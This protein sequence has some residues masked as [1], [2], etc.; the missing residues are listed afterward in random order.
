MLRPAES[1]AAG[2]LSNA[3]FMPPHEVQRHM[4]LLWA[5]ERAI[6]ERIWGATVPTAADTSAARGTRPF[7]PSSPPASSSSSSPLPSSPTH[8]CLAVP[9]PLGVACPHKLLPQAHTRSRFGLPQGAPT[10]LVLRLPSDVQR[11]HRLALLHRTVNRHGF[12]LRLTQSPILMVVLLQR[13]L[14]RRATSSSRWSPCRPT[15]SARPPCSTTS[16]SR[17]LRTS[18]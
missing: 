10:Y 5:R 16:S 3:V 18:T 4:E 14:A 12:L 9:W 8:P 1:K 6:V 17:T 7:L 2:A 13:Q 11:A 15:S